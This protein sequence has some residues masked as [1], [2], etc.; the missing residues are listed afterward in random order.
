MR[1]QFNK[2]SIALA[3]T[4]LTAGTSAWATN[5][6]VLEGYGPVALAMGGAATAIENGTAAMMNNPAT[7]QMGPDGTRFDL[8]VGVLGPKVSTA[9][10]GFPTANSGGTSYLMP[11]FMALACLVKVAWVQS[12]PRTLHWPWVLAL[13]FARNSAWDAYCFRLP[14]KSMTS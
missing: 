6:M 12:T 11:A 1:I 7:L 10:P 13:M 2:K 3:A 4:I 5:G 8:A 9:I 14:C